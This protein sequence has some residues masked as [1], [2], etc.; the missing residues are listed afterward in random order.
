MERRVQFSSEVEARAKAA[1][2]KRERR[3]IKKAVLLFGLAA[4]AFVI[5]H[6][7]I[8]SYHLFAVGAAIT[9]SGAAVFCLLDI[10]WRRLCARRG[11]HFVHTFT[12]QS[13][14]I[15]E[16]FHCREQRIVPTGKDA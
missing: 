8:P 13:V 5:W 4:S 2:L 16:C 14:E 1:A 9:L 12:V 11:H 6:V 10:E 15:Y 7:I 3:D